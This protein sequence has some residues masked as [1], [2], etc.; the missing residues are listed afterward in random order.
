MHSIIQQEADPLWG[1]GPAPSH[2][3]QQ[4]SKVDLM[5]V[6]HPHNNDVEPYLQASFLLFFEASHT[7]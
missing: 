7:Q 4:L 3:Y 1:E 6:S 2:Y 5:Q